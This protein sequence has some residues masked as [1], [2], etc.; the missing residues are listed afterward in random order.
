MILG[1]GLSLSVCVEMTS[2]AVGVCGCGGWEGE[3]SEPEKP[4]I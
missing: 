4:L 1:A 3:V 2:E